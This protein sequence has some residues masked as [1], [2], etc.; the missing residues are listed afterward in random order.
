MSSLSFRIV[1]LPRELRTPD[2]VA[3][4]V[5]GIL[6]YGK[7]S[8]VVIQPKVT[9][10]GMP[11]SSAIVTMED[12]K[13]WARESQELINAGNAGLQMEAVYS[14]QPLSERRQF[15]F[16]NGKPML[17]IKLVILSPGP[18]KPYW[19]SMYIPVV[20]RD[21]DMGQE[22]Y[23]EDL[24]TEQ[25]LK[26]FFEFN[27]ELGVV[28]RVDFVSR[29]IA[30]SELTV[31]SAYVHFHTWNHRPNANTVRNLIDGRGEYKCTG[32]Y[33]V[34]RF[35]PFPNKRFMVFKM[36]KNPIP[37]ANPEANVHQLSASNA[38]LASQIE[39]LKAKIAHLEGAKDG[40]ANDGD[41]KGPMTVEELMV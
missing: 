29:T 24:Q 40:L 5:E 3:W 17:H 21:L 41:S 23:S 31:R 19:M 15:H 12:G 7:V 38:E 14:N 35:I 11:F 26:R 6:L 10:E 22:W 9:A 34:S 13:T 1:T 37:D 20:P 27:L 39:V 4:Y 8:S 16:Q 30:D 33:D 18:E 28:K 25:G 2:D 32:F 36:N